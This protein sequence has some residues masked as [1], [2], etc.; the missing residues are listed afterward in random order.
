MTVDIL[1]L[2]L[3]S[4]V[5]DRDPGV[6]LKEA[7]L[8]PPAAVRRWRRSATRPC[9]DKGCGSTPRLVNRSAR[10]E[11]HRKAPSDT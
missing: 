8:G 3:V 1:G 10:D 2:L 6:L 9:S 5:A 7:F 4:G 11:K